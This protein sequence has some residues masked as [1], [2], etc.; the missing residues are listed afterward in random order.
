MSSILRSRAGL[1]VLVDYA[2]SEIQ[3]E[4]DEFKEFKVLIGD[5]SVIKI[6]SRDEFIDI[7]G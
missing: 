4:K 7:E 2:E 6:E 1:R 3:V 5:K